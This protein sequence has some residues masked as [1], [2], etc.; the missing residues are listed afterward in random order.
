MP[1]LWW[2]ESIIDPSYT[3]E[4]VVFENDSL[5]NETSLLCN[6]NEEVG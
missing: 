4:A 5:V 3:I 1:L 2:M 6:R